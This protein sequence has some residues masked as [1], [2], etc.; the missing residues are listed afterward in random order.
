MLLFVTLFSR[1]SSSVVR[2]LSDISEGNYGLSGISHITVAGAVHH[3]MKEIE[4]WL[5]TFAP[6]SG[7]PIHRH[8]C[9]EVLLVLKGT[10][11]L[12]LAE[13]GLEHPGETTQFQFS[14]NSTIAVPPN[15]VHQIINTGDED[16]QLS[17]VMSRPPVRVFVYQ[18]FSIPHAEAVHFP[19]PWDMQCFAA[20]QG[21]QNS[22]K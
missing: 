12:L 13:P 19:A 9:E 17:A 18:S 2:N 3:G 7:T 6:G 16:V 14:Q 5:Q 11:T 8:D 21:E 1:P 22:C 4:V 10:G 15:S 20:G